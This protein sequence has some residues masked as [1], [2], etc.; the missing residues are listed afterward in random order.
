MFQVFGGGQSGGAA[1]R[2]QKMLASLLLVHLLGGW[3]AKNV[4][5]ERRSCCLSIN[6]DCFIGTP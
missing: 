4:D 2:I 6:S 3:Q 1:F 5:F